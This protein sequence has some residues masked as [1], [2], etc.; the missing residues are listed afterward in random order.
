MKKLL[1]ILLTMTM[2]LSSVC[3][4][5]E[6]EVQA[7]GDETPHVESMEISQYVI[8][9]TRIAPK[10]KV[11]GYENYLFAGWYSDEECTEVSEVTEGSV[12]A[13]FVPAQVLSAGCQ[14]TSTVTDSSATSCDLR[15]VS[16]VDGANYRTVGFKLT[17]GADWSYTSSTTNVFEKITTTT[18]GLDY[19]KTP[20]IFDTESVYFF[21]F[22][23]YNIPSSY[24]SE[25]FY[26][27]PYWVTLDGTEVDGITR[28]ARVEDGYLGYVNVPIR[29]YTDEAV[30]A[31]YLEVSIPG[32][33][34]YIGC[35]SGIF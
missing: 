18:S 17:C 30:A 16:T 6:D 22:K 31:G 14:I 34:T 24:F 4:I 15:I 1:M 28:C 35:D 7:A 27:T 21:T 19:T 29:L 25:A 23:V 3:F 5:S 8:G 10:P 33:C 26:I 9:E 2:I 12:Y 32:G 13:K 20:T 11:S